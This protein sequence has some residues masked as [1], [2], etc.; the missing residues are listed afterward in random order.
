VNLDE[1]DICTLCGSSEFESDDIRAVQRVM[2]WEC[3]ACTFQNGKAD[4]KCNACHN[5]RSAST[6]SDNI[7]VS[8]ARGINPSCGGTRLGVC[9]AV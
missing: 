8:L 4:L 7:H 1:H 6:G 3:A 5:H 9:R 2:K